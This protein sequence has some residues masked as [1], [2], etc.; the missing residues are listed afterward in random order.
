MREVTA[1][2][3]MNIKGSFGLEGQPASILIQDTQRE[4]VFGQWSVIWLQG[5]AFSESNLEETK[6]SFLDSS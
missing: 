6:D 2:S 1:F 4:G 3:E 5:V